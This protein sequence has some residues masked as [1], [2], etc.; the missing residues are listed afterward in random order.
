MSSWNNGKP[1]FR[2]RKM[3]PIPQPPIINIPPQ[4]ATP[5]PVPQPIFTNINETNPSKYVS[6][7]PKNAN[8]DAVICG[9]ALNEELYIDEWINY[10]LALGFNHMY[11]YDNSNNNSLKDRK[12]DKVTIIHFPGKTKQME[13]YNLFIAQ[14]K[15][16]HTWAAFIDCD[17]FIVLKKHGN[18]M[19]FLN[20]YSKYSAVSLNW[21]MFGTS[22]Q[23]TYTNEPVTSRFRYCSKDINIHIKCIAQLKYIDMYENPH[24]PRLNRGYVHDTNKQPIIDSFN[25]LGDSR[26]ACINHYFTKS[27]QEFRDKIERGR[28]DVIQKISTSELDDI[29]T[30]N[31]DV[32]NSD[33]WDFYSRHFPFNK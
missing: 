26:I 16:K 17:E 33:A 3:R 2:E 13:A 30:K 7:I 1:H 18:I 28:A 9:I 27:E 10:H 21:I 24:R 32:Y 23:K 15:T 8:S 31:N 25:R 12:S 29:H 6:N 22:N 5:Q 20:E 11:I 14:Y 4:L 19:A